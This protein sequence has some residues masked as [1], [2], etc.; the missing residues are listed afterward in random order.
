MIIIGAKHS[1]IAKPSKNSLVRGKLINHEDKTIDVRHGQF[2]V[3]FMQGGTGPTLVYL[4]GASGYLGWAPFLDRLAQTFRIIAPAQPGVGN[5]TGLEHL[6]TLWDLIIFYEDLIHELDL[7]TFHLC[8]DG[9]GGM[10]AAELAAHCPRL[11]PKLALTAPF[12]IWIDDN[13][14]LDIFALTR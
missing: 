5:S 7:G 2:Q 4:H 10:I 14:T 11:I 9:Y 13:P 12:G 6:D 3:E 1:F 8:G